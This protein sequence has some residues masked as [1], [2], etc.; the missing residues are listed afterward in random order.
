MMVGQWWWCVL[1]FVVAVSVVES[2]ETTYID[3]GCGCTPMS[4]ALCDIDS[5][6]NLDAPA[7]AGGPRDA[8]AVSST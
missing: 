3:D 6:S 8:S 2:W 4:L 1:A 5:D 7:R